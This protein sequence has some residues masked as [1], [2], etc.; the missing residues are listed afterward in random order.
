M[1]SVSTS[2]SKLIL[3]SVI[4]SLTHATCFNIQAST[5][6]SIHIHACIALIQ[7]PRQH[8]P[9]ASHYSPSACDAP[10]LSNTLHQ[11]CKYWSTE[12]RRQGVCNIE[13]N[14]SRLGTA[15]W[16]FT[17]ASLKREITT[18]S[19]AAVHAFSTAPSVTL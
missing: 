4:A 7:Y 18:P 16:P 6:L 9:H 13:S 10:S 5:A 2:T 3:A 17:C 1:G 15:T 12:H 8:G 14:V 11:V 19:T